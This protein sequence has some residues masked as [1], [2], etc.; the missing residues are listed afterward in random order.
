[1]TKTL[2]DWMLECEQRLALQPKAIREAIEPVFFSTPN[3]GA[4]VTW[5][6]QTQLKTRD[7]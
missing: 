6:N 5:L 2:D 1:M 4:S 7:Q 3:G